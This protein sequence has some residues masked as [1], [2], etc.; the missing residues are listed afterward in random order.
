VGRRGGED[1][2][3]VLAA[4]AVGGR[5]TVVGVG[6]GRISRRHSCTKERCGRETV[7]GVGGGR[8]G[9]DKEEG[10]VAHPQSR[11]RGGPF[12]KLS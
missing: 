7:V 9:R 4:A 3:A 1:D 2:M 6:G 8:R 5:Q 11:D 10:G 12:R